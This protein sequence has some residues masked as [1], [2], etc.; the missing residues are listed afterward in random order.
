[1]LRADLL[2]FKTLSEGRVFKGLFLKTHH[3]IVT[4]PA[5]NSGDTIGKIDN[6]YQA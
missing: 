2:Y 5:G 6:G 3:H 4:A 1:M